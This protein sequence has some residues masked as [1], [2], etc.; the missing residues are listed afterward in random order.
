MIR[1]EFTAFN[2][3]NHG[4]CAYDHL[5]IVDGDGTIL[6]DK[7]CGDALPPVFMSNTHHVDLVFETDYSV[8]KSGWAVNWS[9]VSPDV[10]VSRN[11][12][13]E[14]PNNILQS[15][16]I[17]TDVGKVVV[18]DFYSFDI[19]AHENCNYDHLTI[20]DDDGTK[21]LNKACGNTLPA[22]ITSSTNKVHLIFVTDHSV[23]K[24]GWAINVSFAG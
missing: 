21:L 6:M 5:K 7:T 23:T 16:T 11:Y 2:V 13:R 9:A 14:Y 4:S 22:R 12:P 17:T 24:K 10:V 8:T 19:E 20:T 1:L 3:V 15:E 18:M